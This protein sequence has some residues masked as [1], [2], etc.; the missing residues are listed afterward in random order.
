V[1]VFARRHPSPEAAAKR[2]KEFSTV[3]AVIKVA[4]KQH[5]VE[6]GRW[7][8]IDQ[9]EAQDIVAEVLLVADGSTVKT[10]ADAAKATVKLS[11]AGTVRIRGNRSMKFKTKEGRSS[12]RMLGYRRTLVKVSCDS[13]SL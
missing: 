3:Y 4:G 1:G 9:P 10:G 13:I 12:K 5:R 8:L 2:I 6:K 11:K 7:F